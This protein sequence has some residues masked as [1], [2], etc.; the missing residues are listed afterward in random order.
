MF[1]LDG[2]YALVTG[3][4]GTLG[5]AISIGLASAGADV[6]CHYRNSLETVEKL[7]ADIEAMGRKCLLIQADLSQDLEGERVVEETAGYFGEITSAL[8]L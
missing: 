3:A 2:K 4:S 8:R 1:R 6:A 5:K 7:K